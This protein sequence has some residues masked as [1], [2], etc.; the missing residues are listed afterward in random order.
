MSRAQVRIGDSHT[1][2]TDVQG[3]SDVLVNNRGVH[4]RTDRDSCRDPGPGFQQ[5]ASTTVFANNLG[6]AG[7]G[8]VNNLGSPEITGSDDVFID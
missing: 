8:H 7:V 3:S 2:G 4:R 1:C 5:Q 6:R